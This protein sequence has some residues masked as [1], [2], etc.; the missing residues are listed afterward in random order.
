MLLLLLLLLAR[1]A[2]GW[3]FG[4][5]RFAWLSDCNA[6]GSYNF[7]TR[8]CNCDDG[9]GS[10]GDVS[11]AKSPRC[12][13]RICPAGPALASIPSTTTAGHALRECSDA[14]ACD[15]GTGECV[16]Y[17]GFA[18]RACEKCKRMGMGSFLLLLLLLLLERFLPFL[19]RARFPHYN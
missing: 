14:G 9:W 3:T 19:S 15:R 18:G 10:A 5:G 6:H 8:S 17:G 16:C 12:D 13:V 2:T 7:Q 1:P 11:I 4:N